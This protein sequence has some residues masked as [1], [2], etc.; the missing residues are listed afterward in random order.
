[1]AG[2]DGI[3]YSRSDTHLMAFSLQTG[4]VQ[5][6]LPHDDNGYFVT[7]QPDGGAVVRIGEFFHVLDG[8]GGVVSSHSLAAAWEY[9]VG[10][11][12]WLDPRPEGVNLVLGPHLAPSRFAAGTL[13]GYQQG[14][15][16]EKTT[17]SYFVT[18]KIKNTPP[19]PVTAESFEEEISEKPWAGRVF[20]KDA[21]T[22]A[23]FEQEAL[24]SPHVLVFLGHALTRD[25]DPGGASALRFG[26]GGT[27]VGAFYL[28]LRMDPPFELGLPGQTKPTESVETRSRVLYL[29]AC[30]VG[31]HMKILLGFNQVQEKRAMIWL[32]SENPSV[33]LNHAREAW[34]LL[35][36]RLSRGLTVAQAVAEVNN[37]LPTPEYHITDR[38]EYYGDPNTTIR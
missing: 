10:G 9:P 33:G 21:F 6:A 35:A 22:I 16:I 30:N 2:E 4:T 31:D 7:P 8:Q 14:S 27:I 17:F 11:A 15:G 36:E 24:R 26:D 19:P 18:D 32:A 25:D 23:N 12:L 13:R 38:L 29:G 28:V 20:Y 34:L 5:W 37:L 3:V 1:M